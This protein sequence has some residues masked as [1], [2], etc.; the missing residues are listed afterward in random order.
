[1]PDPELISARPQI[2]WAGQDDARLSAALLE[3]TVVLP[4]EGLD[5]LELRAVD[6][7]EPDAPR[8]FAFDDLK[9]GDAVEIKLGPSSAPVLV[10]S[11]ECTAL[12]AVLGQGAPQLVALAEDKLHR[13]A[14]ARHSRVFANV[15]VA[16]VVRQVGQGHGLDVD[17]DVTSQGTWHQLGESDLA[18]VRRLLAPHNRAPRLIDGV[19]KAKLRS[20]PPVRL[21]RRAQQRAARSHV[22]GPG[23]SA[24]PHDGRRLRHR[25]G[26]SH[27]RPCLRVDS[28]AGGA[29]RHRRGSGAWAEARRLRAT[30]R[31]LSQAQGD[32]Q[33]LAALARRGEQLV[34]GELTCQGN[35][36]LKPGGGVRLAGVPPRFAGEYGVASCVHRL[37]LTQGYRTLVRLSRGGL[38]S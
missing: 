33:A 4:A 37:N 13:L 23:A 34:S 8:P 6:L 26:A 22:R 27:S 36:G 29:Q 18:F 25:A 21:S 24:R 32:A 2:D 35:P 5:R 14:K 1:M 20:R 17:C 19:L 7:G 15:S 31:R 3:L 9:L 16:D 28:A 10:F 12:E 38:A 30:A 11:G